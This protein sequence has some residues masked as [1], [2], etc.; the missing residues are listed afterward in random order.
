MKSINGLSFRNIIKKPVR[1][2]ALIIIAAFL[3]FSAFGGSVMVMS[4]SGGL[5]SLSARL[6]AD[7]VVVPYSATSKVSYDS[8]IIQGQPGQFYMDSKYYDEIKEEISGIEKITAQFYLASAKASCCSSRLQIIGF[9]P[10]TD[11]SVQPWIEKSY[12]D[13]LGLYDTVV[14]SDVTPNTDMTIE[15]YGKTLKVQSVLDKTGTELDHAIYVNTETMKELIKAHNE[16]NPNQEREVN[17]DNVVSSV[18]IKVSGGYDIDSVVG[19]INLHV[20][21]VKAIRT[22]NMISDV[23]DSLSG[24]SGMISALMIAVWALSVI[25]MAIAFTMI[26]N[27][28]KKEFAVLRVLGASR[29]RLAGF[30]FKENAILTLTGGVIGV[31]LTVIII[32]LFSPLIE[33]SIGLPFLLPNAVTLCVAGLITVIVTVAAGALTAAISAFKIS[34]LDTGLILRGD[35]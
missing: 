32:L 19:D 34:K 24:V 6:G 25:I 30:V 27:E 18:L 10:E 11:F 31:L 2:A 16:K 17:P 9:D 21:Q 26:M 35:N 15:I 14:G 28:R 12:S 3:A 8:I 1:S 7:I 22:Q 23:A 5:N 20:R 13:K 33:Q 29:A 4:L